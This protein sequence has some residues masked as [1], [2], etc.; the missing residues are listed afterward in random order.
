M[1]GAKAQNRCLFFGSIGPRWTAAKIAKNMMQW[2]AACSSVG[3]PLHS[4]SMCILGVKVCKPSPCEPCSTRGRTHRSIFWD[5]V[6]FQCKSLRH[7]VR[8]ACKGTRHLASST[9]RT[10]GIT[11][12]K[13]HTGHHCVKALWLH[14]KCPA[15]VVAGCPPQ[16]S[17]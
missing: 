13:P 12:G 10:L 17:T 1:S 4:R 5:P 16:L 6:L 9:H 2:I 15:P 8:A 14:S 11:S 3:I 7:A